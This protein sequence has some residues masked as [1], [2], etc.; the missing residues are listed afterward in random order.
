M[1]SNAEHKRQARY[2]RVIADSTDIN[3]RLERLGARSID[4]M[5]NASDT[6]ARSRVRMQASDELNI[7]IDRLLGYDG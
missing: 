7:E 2:L 1:P 5:L 3:E 6:L 4:A